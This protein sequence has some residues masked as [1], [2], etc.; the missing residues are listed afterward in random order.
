MRILH[1][2]D[3]HI[4]R[5]FHGHST[6]DALGAVLDVVVAQVRENE[7]DVVVIAGDLFDSSTPSAPA[8]RL[9]SSTLRALS[10]TGAAV[11]ATSGNHDSAA[12][13]GF[14]SALLRDGVHVVTDPLALDVPLTVQ[15][16]DGD[17]DFYGIPYLE[18]SVVRSQWPGVDLRTQEQTMRHAMSLVT[19]SV[20]RRSN[21]SVVIAHTFAA[22]VEA[23][24]G[25]EREVRTSTGAA[26]S[27]GTI[28]VVPVSVF[29]GIDYTALGH[30][31]SRQ[32]L[33]ERIAYSGAPLHYSFGERDRPRGSWLVDLAA[34]GSVTS[35]W[36]PLPVPRRLV[37]L[38]GPLDELLADPA[39]AEHADAWVAVEYTDTTPQRDAMRRLQT[40]FPYCATVVH[41]PAERGERE[42][43]TYAERLRAAVTDEER[44]EAFLVH[45]RGGEGLTPAE[46]EILTAVLDDRRRAESAA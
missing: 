37:L 40:R 9:L 32:Q 42:R 2:S 5:T 28:D 10:D 33:T 45:V 24:A 18:P 15:G 4:G 17:V 16:T 26:L 44:V 23:T 34:D 29:E 27:Q 31:H 7:V 13:L 11:I 6:L 35:E 12:R 19:A 39:F 30:I 21:R 22:G 20:R 36:L 38:R 46:S 43:R 8:Y 3:W 41:T 25:L 1:T 14:Q